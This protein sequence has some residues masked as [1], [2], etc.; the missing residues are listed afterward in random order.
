MDSFTYE[1]AV[2][3]ETDE[4]TFSPVLPSFV[5]TLKP[6]V[7]VTTRQKTL[8]RPIS[9]VGIGL[10]TGHR[11]SLSIEPAPVN[12]GIV[13]QRTDISAAPI[14]ALYDHVVE[15]RLSTVIGDATH[16]E[17]RVATIEHL[18][19]ALAGLGI[20]NVRI[21]VDGP[22]LPV[23]D[24]SSADF[25][26]L[27]DCAGRLEQEAPRR[28]IRIL[29]PVHVES[30]SASVTL[31]PAE[32]SAF[33]LSMSIDFTASAIGCQ[34]FDLRLTEM[35]FRKE[36]AFSRTFTNRQEIETLRSM[37]LA[38]GG[39]LDN[40]IVVDEDRILNPTGL[41]ASNEFVRHKLLDAVGD[42][43]LAGAYIHGHFVGSRSGHQLNNTLLRKLFADRSAWA[44][45]P[46]GK[47]FSA[48]TS[49][50]A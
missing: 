17:N 43:A 2:T 28:E 38:L 26:F 3:V 27:L 35:A 18:M 33:A 44:D 45:I 48:H 32:N 21:F 37:G 6:L 14:P 41:R 46:A 50:A 11:I 39:S 20:D 25:V 1:P 9:C 36:L 40:A 29:K 15:T 22:E 24:G 12:S 7:H 42:L 47:T 31:L 16:R 5:K 4:D 30:G 13:F 49:V 19:S 10:H 34:N 23:L 8:A